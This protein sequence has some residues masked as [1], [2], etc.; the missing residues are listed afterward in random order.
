M[1]TLK[2]ERRS[3]RST[4]AVPLP[5]RGDARFRRDAVALPG[6]RAAPGARRQERPVAGLAAAAAHRDRPAPD[7]RAGRHHQLHHLRPRPAAACVRRRQGAAAISPSAA[8]APAR[9][10]LALDGKT[11][12]LDETMCVIAD[13]QR[14]RIAR[15]HHGR[16]GLRLL[17]DDHRRA[18]RIGAV[19][20]RSTSRRPAASSASTPTRA[21]ASSAASIRPSWCRASS[22]RPS[23][24]LD[25]C[26]GDAV[27]DHGRRRAA[28]AASASSISRST[29]V[30]RLA[31]L[32]VRLPE[33][34]ARAR[35]SRLLRRR[36]GPSREGRGA[37][38]AARRPRQ[39]RH[40]RGGRAHHRRRPRAVDA[41]RARRRARA[42]RC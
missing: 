17:G 10:S 42:S 16:R 5:G 32:D 18:D 2:D 39:G 22:S 35:P 8:P 3:S 36:P 27:R 7:Q 23:M 37:D 21:T 20:R 40:R 15:R 11:Y 30:K 34:Q 28:D 38:L 19:G 9:R 13:E 33:M 12:T 6:L 14:R 29:E 4:G 41:V 24:V 26:G 31:G 1:G 25:L